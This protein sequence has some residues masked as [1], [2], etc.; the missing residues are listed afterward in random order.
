M[1]SHF[2]DLVNPRVKSFSGL[3]VS[4]DIFIN[5]HISYLVVAEGS[6]S[7]PT[8]VFRSA[9]ICSVPV[10]WTGGCELVCGGV[11]WECVVM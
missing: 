8:N 11:L 4:G 9:N 3:V 5:S 6:H 10:L 2:L 7:E 1:H